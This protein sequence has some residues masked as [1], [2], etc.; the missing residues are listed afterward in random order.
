MKKEEVGKFTEEVVKQVI[1]GV[2]DAQRNLSRT[3]VKEPE[4]IDF[5]VEIEGHYLEYRILTK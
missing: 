3:S 4:Y 5:N 2:R 1:Q